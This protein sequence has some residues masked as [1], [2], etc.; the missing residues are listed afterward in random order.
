MFTQNL[1]TNAAYSINHNGQV[2]ATQMSN[3]SWMDIRCGVDLTI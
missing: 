3:N 1:C 2:E